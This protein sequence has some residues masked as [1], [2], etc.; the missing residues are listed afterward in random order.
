MEIFIERLLYSAVAAGIMI[1]VIIVA[2]P[3]LKRLPKWISLLL[4][5]IVGLKFPDFHR[6]NNIMQKIF[7]FHFFPHLKTKKQQNAV[8]DYILYTIRR[9]YT[10]YKKSTLDDSKFQKIVLFIALKIH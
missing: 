3:F 10:E 5:L 8:H 7:F 6:C 2:R 9:Q 1:A 4:W